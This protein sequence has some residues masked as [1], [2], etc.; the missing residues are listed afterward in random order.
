MSLSVINCRKAKLIDKMI[1]MVTKLGVSVVRLL[2]KL[3]SEEGHIVSLSV[4]NC[5][6]AKVN[7]EMVA[8]VI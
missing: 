6:K 3:H 7:N 4:A 5:P 8:M 1:S 2:Q